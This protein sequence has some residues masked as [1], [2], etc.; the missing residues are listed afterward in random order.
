VTE[1][2]EPVLDEQIR[3]YRARA[4]EYDDW[5]FRRGRYDHGRDANARWFADQ[6]EVEAALVRFEPT[7]DVLELACGTGLWTAKLHADAR[8]LTAVDVSPEVLQLAQSRVVDSRVEYV[9]ADLFV[10]EPLG[11]YDVC[12]F[13]F[14]LS[15]VPEEHFEAFWA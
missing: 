10:W 15:H 9:Q 7:G 5:W 13:S 2:V 3:Y 8:S 6:S 14:W 4:C 12:F 11:N 1:E